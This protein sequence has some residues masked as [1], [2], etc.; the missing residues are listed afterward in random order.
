[1]LAVYAGAKTQPDAS[2]AV[3][4]LLSRVY[5]EYT[6]QPM[7]PIEVMPGGKPYWAESDWHFSLCHTRGLVLCA[8]SDHPV[9]LDAERIRTVRPAVVSRVLAPAE[10]RAYDGTEA[11]FLRFWTL[12]EAYAKYTGEGI[13]GYPNRFVFRLT[14]E[15]AQMEGNDLHFATV[16]QNDYIIST[17]TPKQEP[18]S[19]VWD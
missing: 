8:L 2:A 16:C 19:I 3:R 4:Q 1:M 13:I 14:P 15:G 11:M 17:C 9:G 6:G 18:L 7:P 5:R 12:K 10:L